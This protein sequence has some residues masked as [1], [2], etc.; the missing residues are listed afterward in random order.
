[1]SHVQAPGRFSCLEEGDPVTPREAEL[2][3]VSPRSVV[4]ALHASW[5]EAGDVFSMD[6]GVTWC[7]M[8]SEPSYADE[9]SSDELILEA[10]TVESE[11]GERTWIRR[12]SEKQL[13]HIVEERA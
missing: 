10:G 7:R 2:L 5:L 3:G 4:R 1:M 11:L 9:A 6:E 12:V 8:Q 13:V